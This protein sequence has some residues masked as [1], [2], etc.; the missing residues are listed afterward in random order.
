MSTGKIKKKERT[1]KIIQENNGFFKCPICSN[2]M[3]VGALN[4]LVCKKDH[5]YDLSKKGSINFMGNFSNPVYSKELF[6]A[7][8]KV[9]K[10]GFYD[11]LLEELL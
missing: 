4:S 6:E 10:A 5:L 8:N 7:R 2:P 9:C 11:P 3:R 1:I